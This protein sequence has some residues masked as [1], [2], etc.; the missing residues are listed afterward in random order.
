MRLPSS[1]LLRPAAA[2]LL[3]LLLARP[4]AGQGDLV[5]RDYAGD[6]GNP[7]NYRYWWSSP[8]INPTEVVG[9]RDNAITVRCRNRGNSPVAEAQ[10]DLYYNYITT[11]TPPYITLLRSAE[12]INPPAAPGRWVYIGRD[13][14]RNVAAGQEAMA[15][16]TV[17][18]PRGGHMC[19]LAITRGPDDPFQYTATTDRTLVVTRNNNC[20]QRNYCQIV[21]RPERVIEPPPERVIDPVPPRPV[22]ARIVEPPTPG[23]TGTVT[24]IKWHDVNG[25]GQ[26]EPNEP[27][28]A[29][30][31]I[32]IDLNGNGAHD[33][34][35]PSAVTAAQG[36]YRIVGIAPGRHTCREVVPTGMT[37]SFPGTGT[38]RGNGFA[39]VVLE[40][41]DS[42]RGPRPGPYGVIKTR[43]LT[44]CSAD[45]VLG[46]PPPGPITGRNPAVEALGLPTDTYVT[47]GFTDETVNDGPG[48]DLFIRSFDPSDSANES[49]DVFVSANATDFVRLGRVN[50]IGNV[51]LDLASIGFTQ[52]VKAVRVVGLDNRGSNPGFDLISVEVLP[53]SIGPVNA[54]LVN[55][56]AGGVV[57]NI[58]FGNRGTPPPPPG[59][60][61][62]PP[63]VTGPPPGP[64]NPPP[65]ITGPPPTGPTRIVEPP[66]IT[67]GRI[68][69]ERTT[70]QCVSFFVANQ[71]DRQAKRV[72][73]VVD[74]TRVPAGAQV[75]LVL[76]GLQSSVS[77]YNLRIGTVTAGQLCPVD[78]VTPPTTENCPRPVEGC[79]TAYYLIPGT[80]GEVRDVPLLAAH[81]TTAYVVVTERPAL[82][83]GASFE[84]HVEQHE[85]GVIQGGV[86]F[87]VSMARP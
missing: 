38:T 71:D 73:L 62:P 4:S 41:H 45:I 66:E 43:P 28:L 18:P 53:N 27:G 13:V 2:A 36:G 42:G 85:A 77:V 58:N 39:D 35:E 24:G 49:A 29:G 16:F 59:P 68:T 22:E 40:F 50:E 7:H 34:N 80:L 56:T 21:Y 72:T 23:G 74:A 60:Q 76:P 75:A 64:Q 82:A 20:A 63:V 12:D 9:G 47:V 32:Y 48:N 33:S 65:V 83:P 69:D 25:N 6:T 15:R 1:R 52:P 67:T 70:S 54:H 31:T 8:D 11:C 81:A 26:R 30:V 78:G 5:I 61:N 46:P 14:V 86:G 51:G 44:P 84:F 17:R 19:L 79:V 37:L 55:V 87:K 10:V 3:G 57:E